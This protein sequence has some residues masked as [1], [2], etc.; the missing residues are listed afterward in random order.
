[1][2]PLDTHRLLV[3][4]GILAI[5]SIPITAQA[6]RGPAQ[7]AMAERARQMRNK[8]PFPP[9][10]AEGRLIAQMDDGG[11]EVDLDEKTRAALDSAMDELREAE[12]AYGEKGKVAFKK[13]HDLLDE[14]QPDE[15]AVIEASEAI[16][17]LGTEM[18]NLRLSATL[19]FRSLLTPDQLKKYMKLRKQL[20]PSRGGT[21]RSNR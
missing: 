12:D 6:Q 15:K 10:I 21:A 19:K 18:R 16:G 3:V 7:E 14:D 20:P 9:G 1:M 11:E 17:V 2:R 8:P 5:V 13:L 4:C